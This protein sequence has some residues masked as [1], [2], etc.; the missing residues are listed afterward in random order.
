MV[1]SQFQ[2]IKCYGWALFFVL[3]KKL[4]VHAKMGTTLFNSFPG[5]PQIP[6]GI[7]GPIAQRA[8][9]VLH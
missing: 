8:M 1:F 2:G 3:A 7:W 5:F 4:L 9:R 6:A